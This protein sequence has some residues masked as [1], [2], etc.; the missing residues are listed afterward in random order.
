MEG[1][2]FLLYAWIILGGGIYEDKIFALGTST[3]Y[4]LCSF[5]PEK[6]KKNKNLLEFRKCHWYP[7][8]LKELFD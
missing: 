1:N 3:G 2:S 5:A 7:A 8:D 6:N 4:W